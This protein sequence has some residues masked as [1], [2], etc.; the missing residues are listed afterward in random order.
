MESAARSIPWLA[1]GLVVLAGCAAPLE[2]TPEP[3]VD[4]WEVVDVA[5]L[6][7]RI[8][9]AVSEGADWP[10]SPIL[11]ALEVLGGE[12]DAREIAI[13]R[14][15]NRAEAA[16]TAV[17]VITRDRF[18]DDSVRGDWHRIVLRRL[19]DWTWRLHEVRRAFRCW[20]GHHLESYSAEWCL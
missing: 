2:H 5:E 15:M 13:D 16:D 9:D 1:L 20:R 19:G 18:L 8:D 14:R 3:V 7:A 10:R 6:N 4:S 12:A 11:T 17:V